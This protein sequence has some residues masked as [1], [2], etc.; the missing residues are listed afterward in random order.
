MD[1][2]KKKETQIALILST[3]VIVVGIVVMV[4]YTSPIEKF[5]RAIA[6]DNMV[7]AMNLYNYRL[8]GTEDEGKAVNY[9]KG[10]LRTLLDEFLAGEKSYDAAIDE[11]D[12]FSEIPYTAELTWEIKSDVEYHYASM[13][14]FSTAEELYAMEKYKEAIGYYLQVVK[15]DGNYEAAQVKKAEAIGKYKEK[16]IAQVD[17]LVEDQKYNE[18]NTI[19]MEAMG[20]LP[21]DVELAEKFN[22]VGVEQEEFF[23]QGAVEN[24][25]TLLTEGK[26]ADAV[27]VAFD[28]LTYYAGNAAVENKA[29]EA[30]KTYEDEM[31]AL[32]KGHLENKDLDSAQAAVNE[33]S[34]LLSDSQVYQELAETVA[35]YYP[36]K[37]TELVVMDEAGIQE[38]VENPV[39]IRG[40][41][42]S[43]GIHYD[44]SSYQPDPVNDPDRQVFMLNKAYK[45]F[46][47]TLVASEECKSEDSV[48]FKIIAIDENNREREIFAYT[49]TKTGQPIP[50]E[51]D[52]TGVDQLKLVFH[53]MWSWMDAHYILACPELLQEIL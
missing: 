24:I 19:L 42:Y 15:E 25:D 10:E 2:L 52:V 13:T 14:A 8:A 3:I 53:F 6:D 50:I 1:S 35:K 33:M 34:V 38:V 26:T 46:R 20:V 27:L 16:V 23:V 32:V 29:N 28:A 5:K 22:L 18:A 43:W 48:N 44:G 45:K 17:T 36:V 21:E 40:N 11:L 41:I 47:A 37:L 9:V 30:I 39:D 49:L 4:K 31:S 12:A 7:T 51:L